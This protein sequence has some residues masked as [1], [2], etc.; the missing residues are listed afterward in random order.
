MEICRLMHTLHMAAC[1]VRRAFTA[2][3][4]AAA[5]PFSVLI[6]RGPLPDPQS[7]RSARMAAPPPRRSW[8]RVLIASASKDMKGQAMRNARRVT[9]ALSR[10]YQ[11]H[12][13]GRWCC[14]RRVFV[15]GARRGNTATHWGVTSARIAQA[16]LTALLQVRLLKAVCVLMASLD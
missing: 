10:P 14:R 16:I 3:Q 6:I 5:R 2:R 13:L 8:C 9:R 12:C 1:G 15:S 11:S 7:A 4:T